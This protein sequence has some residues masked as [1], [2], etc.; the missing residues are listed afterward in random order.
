MK[1]EITDH[2]KNITQRQQ[3]ILSHCHG[4]LPKNCILA[5]IFL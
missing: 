1:P 5:M 3:N 4:I 2:K